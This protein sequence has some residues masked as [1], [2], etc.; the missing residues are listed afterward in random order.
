MATPKG[1]ILWHEDG[2][3]KVWRFEA[4]DDARACYEASDAD[5]KSLRHVRYGAGGEWEVEIGTDPDDIVYFEEDELRSQA[6]M[7]A[8]ERNPDL[9]F[10]ADDLADW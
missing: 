6:L 1:G 8:M 4:E 7:L 5:E 10:T 2:D 3:Y 9:A